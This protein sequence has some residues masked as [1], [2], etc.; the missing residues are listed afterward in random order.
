[1]GG[2]VTKGIFLLSVFT[3]IFVM[4]LVIVKER[5]K[6]KTIDTKRKKNHFTKTLDIKSE[7]L[8]LN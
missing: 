1:M 6:Q 3:A 5:H 2:L 8:N 7:R 4:V